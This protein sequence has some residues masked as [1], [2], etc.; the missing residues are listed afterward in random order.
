MKKFAKIFTA[1]AVAFA[2]YSCVTDATED[3]VVNLGGG[4][5]QTTITLSLEESRVQLGEK[6]DG[7]YPLYWSNGDQI[8]INGVAS[9]ELV[10]VQD[11]ATEASFSFGE[12]EYPLNIV[13]PAAEGEAVEGCYPVV[14]PAVQQYVAGNVDPKAVA[15]YGY[16]ASAPAEGEVAT[17]AAL[18]H[19]TGVL[20]LNVKGSVTLTSLSVE[21]RGGNIAGTYNVDCVSG[22]LTATED[23]E[24]T[25]T[26][27][28]D[29]GLTLNADEATPIYVTVPAGVHG[30]V[31][32]T[33]RTADDKMTVK[34]NSIGKP[35]KAGIVR[36][37][38]EFTYTPNTVEDDS[39]VYEIDGVDKLIEFAGMAA[40]FT[41]FNKVVVTADIA[42]PA[43]QTWTPIEG[44]GAFEFDGGG[45]TISGLTAPLFG[46][47]NAYIHDLNLTDVVLNIT[48]NGN[49]GAFARRIVNGALVNCS[50]SGDSTINCAEYDSP[51]TINSYSVY[52]H[53]GLVGFVD[54][55]TID[56]CTN[57]VAITIQRV[58]KGS[59][60]NTKRKSA[61]G[62]I[63]GAH[64]GL[65]SFTNLTNEGTISYTG[66]TQKTTMYIS[67][68]V[69]RDVET[70]SLG[71]RNVAALSNCTNKAQINTHKDSKSSSGITL[72]GITG[73]LLTTDDVVVSNLKNEG[74]LYF[75]G[76]ATACYLG[77][78][79]GNAGKAHFK[80]CSNSAEVMQQ[81]TSSVERAYI[82][83]IVTNVG[84]NCSL[85]NCNNSGSL[86]MYY[87]T[88]PRDEYVVI[89]GIAGVLNDYVT[90]RNCQNTAAEINIHSPKLQVVDADG[91]VTTEGVVPAPYQ[92]RIGGIVANNSTGS[93]IENCH[94]AGRVRIRTVPTG[95][96]VGGI[97]G[98]NEHTLVVRNC[99]NSGSVDTN[100]ICGSSSYEVVNKDG[101]KETIRVDLY[102]GGICGKSIEKIDITNC[103]NT[104]TGKVACTS[105]D[106][107]SNGSHT[108]IAGILG[109]SE[110][111]KLTNII[112]CTNSGTVQYDNKKSKGNVGV[113]GVIG[114][115]AAYSHID[116]CENASTA[117]VGGKG[118]AAACMGFG[119]IVG[120]TH[121]GD[122]TVRNCKN[123]GT[124]A[125]Q[126]TT[127]LGNGGSSRWS[128]GTGLGGIVGIGAQIY[129]VSNCENYGLITIANTS[130]TN[131][132]KLVHLYAGGVIGWAVQE[133]NN[134]GAT[135]GAMTMKNLANYADLTF[136]GAAGRYYAGG[137]VGCITTHE[138][139]EKR[140]W[141]E[142]SGLKNVANLTFDVANTC[143]N[144]A[145][146]GVIGWAAQDYTGKE[147]TGIIDLAGRGAEIPLQSCEHYGN[148]EI[149]DAEGK[150]DYT[151]VGAIL[152]CARSDA[153]IVK[154][155]SKIG[156][157]IVTGKVV[158][159]EHE[160]F[161]S[162]VMVPETVEYS[163]Y[164][165]GADNWYTFLYKG[166]VEQSVA[167][168]DGC[169]YYQEGDAVPTKPTQQN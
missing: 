65:C 100:G 160:D 56:N 36:E 52:A 112:D 92:Y 142:I 118:T 119:G 94:N 14:F 148:I 150:L 53:G 27:I 38:K 161:N 138:T 24:D 50:A 45:K 34:F 168:A 121:R 33:L 41:K 66:T 60:G 133:Q 104:S 157:M 165:L 58:Y 114:Y 76:D 29:E 115:M 39:D 169:G 110:A 44:F 106:T 90:V 49:S 162:G 113:G 72:S 155:N 166:G 85:D 117:V 126:N 102:M 64:V 48:D 61:I 18:K 149:L 123:Y 67:G 163:G 164:T 13:F 139:A 141:A 108:Y 25:V 129:E 57:D 154:N 79:V 55:V 6:V 22:L 134:S 15:L 143:P 70:S 63:A 7:V 159:P 81:S 98:Y 99:T 30:A 96:A 21:A 82:S 35:V 145:L 80:N 31:W 54:G 95:A 140:W 5:G 26:M 167:E 10:N 147:T 156:G 77:G 20:Q 40:N 153:G 146:G 120:T 137:V 128:Y 9:N 69:G 73:Y 46:V 127:L 124:I 28:F 51:E 71:D 125:Q 91:K 42:W 12:L 78:I 107:D 47:T 87:T 135:F 103:E 59:G 75:Y 16:V 23:A 93:L 11:N 3:L 122:I 84:D 109:A 8:A 17:S 158:T 74:A 4:E 89:G 152:G 132:D 101:K 2:A 144:S 97:V 83:G 136:T 68:I 105:T 130:V 111:N 116:N 151:N 32:V 37:F 1:V 86:R 19:L 62:G 88:V 43:K 131:S